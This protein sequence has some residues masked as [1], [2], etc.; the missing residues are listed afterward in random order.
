MS[1]QLR[2][3]NVEVDLRAV[4][5]AVA[6]RLPI[7]IVLSL[8][9]GAGVFAM[10]SFVDPMYRA[11]TTILIET[12]ESDLTGADQ[13][14]TALLLDREGI[15][16]Q[17]ELI[18]SRDVALA[19]IA[20]LDLAN[21]PEFDPEIAEPSFVDRVLGWVGL[22]G[23]DPDLP[24]E[25]VVLAEFRKRLSVFPIADTRVIAIT[26]V[27][28][29]PQLAADIANAV[30][31]QYINR[32]RAVRVQTTAEA[33]A[34]LQTEIAAL[35]ERV[36]QAETDVENYRAQQDLFLAG[37]T[38]GQTPVT[39]V[40]QRLA[41]L[42]SELSRVESARAEAEAKANLIRANLDSGAALS[43]LDIL[44]S[45]L[46]QNLREQQ[47]LL[48][49]QIA[50]ASAT[51]LPNH[52][53]IQGLNAQ[54][55]DLN[56]AIRAEA[57]NILLGLENEA[58][59]ARGYEAELN[60][61]MDELKAAAALS[62]QA[63]VQLRALERV[64]T[65]EAQLLETYLALAREAVSRQSADFIPVNARIVSPA[66]AP[67]EAYFPKPVGM[68]AIAAIITF[69]LGAAFLLVRAL[70]GGRAVRP[71]RAEPPMERPAAEADGRVRWDEND[72]V[73]RM[74]PTD[75]SDP[76]HLASRIEQS[77]IGIAR[78]LR[79]KQ[80]KRVLITM[81][82]GPQDSGRPLAAVALARTMARSGARVLL[83]D[84]HAD[85]AD[86]IAMGEEDQLPGFGDLFA[87]D[88][89]F[90]QVIFRDRSSPVHFIPTG[91]RVA[92]EEEP[93]RFS[94]LTDILEQTYDH[95]VYDISDRFASM[96]GPDAGATVVLTD[97]EPTDPQTIAAFDRMKELSP[98]EILLLV[99]APPPGEHAAA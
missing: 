45:T 74:M 78:K 33:T 68:T 94:E 44:N 64:A 27:A 76:S 86:R 83:V 57:T 61:Q 92:F 38:T 3:D 72:D 54:L 36:I 13:T 81:A 87:G 84:L 39:L 90:A 85:D 93:Q 9:V 7:L 8:L 42:S 24:V 30:A 65:A 25:E 11:E 62:N 52:P 80:A 16:S 4:F 35:S 75:P 69:M 29:D 18:R 15:A 91:K 58:E 95:V 67:I 73:R 14:Q 89:S 70:A 82:E 41:D 31:Q 55:A 23:D 99:T 40:A 51:Y 6:R 21:V 53:V 19:V 1:E 22:G 98:A 49:A 26:F 17:V 71:V 10:L 79:Q 37:Q 47:V 66:A 48:Q 2:S 32:Q 34:W 28:T 46:I 96:L 5:G 12:S 43:S 59:L 97:S 88:A 20:Q 77:L 50:E 60:A 63:E 56:D